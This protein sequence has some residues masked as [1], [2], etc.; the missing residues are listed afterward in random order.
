VSFKDILSKIQ[1]NLK[2]TEV[3]KNLCLASTPA[4][5]VGR[6]NTIINEYDEKIYALLAGDEIFPSP[7]DPIKSRRKVH[8]FKIEGSDE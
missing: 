4:S 1:S 3:S 7:A 8:E 5:F 6:L 2:N